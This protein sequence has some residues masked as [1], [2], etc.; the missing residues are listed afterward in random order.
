M[1]SGD[2]VV[3]GLGIEV[4]RNIGKKLE[5]KEELRRC[6]REIYFRVGGRRSDSEE[7]VSCLPV[8]LTPLRYTNILTTVS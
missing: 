3:L 7:S 6:E 5:G 4:L 2:D 8:T 1:G